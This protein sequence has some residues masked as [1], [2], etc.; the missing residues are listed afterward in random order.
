[1][2]ELGRRASVCVVAKPDD[3]YDVSTADRDGMGAGG[4]GVSAPMRP[5]TDGES[6][7]VSGRFLRFEP[8][9]SLGHGRESVGVDGGLLGGRLRPPC[10]ARRFVVLPHPRRGSGHARRPPSGRVAPVAPTAAT[11]DDWPPTGGGDDH[12]VRL[13]SRREFAA[14]A[15]E[16]V[17]RPRLRIIARRM[18]GF[19]FTDA[20]G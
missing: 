2:R 17:C 19:R 18:F 11:Q 6:G 4:G 14:A 20:C 9:G 3:G 12:A 15:G 13:P 16:R 1:M 7:N 8:I 10:V 5:R